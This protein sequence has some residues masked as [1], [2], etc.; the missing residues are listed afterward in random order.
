MSQF[1]GNHPSHSLIGQPVEERRIERHQPVLLAVA[2]KVVRTH[3]LD[4]FE[5]ERAGV[6]RRALCDIDAEC[7][8][9]IPSRWEALKNFAGPEPYTDLAGHR[10]PSGFLLPTFH[11]PLLSLLS[12]VRARSGL[13]SA[14]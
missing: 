14:A 8:R 4:F 7:A 6:A 3:I 12:C 10:P 1:V 5:S 11:R 13:Y 9:F 2:L